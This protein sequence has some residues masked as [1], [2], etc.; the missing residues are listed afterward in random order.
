MI[1]ATREELLSAL[2]HLITDPLL[3]RQLGDQAARTAQ[4]HTWARNAQS[5]WEWLNEVARN[6][7]AQQLV[8]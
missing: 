6:K 8:L 2:R 1:H 7:S 5:T 4:D 3:C